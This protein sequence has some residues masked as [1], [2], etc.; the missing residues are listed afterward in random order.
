MLY[1][2]VYWK[3]LDVLDTSCIE[4]VR[5]VYENLKL[6]DLYCQYEEETYKKICDQI[7]AIPLKVQ[8]T[9]L[10]ETLNRTFN[11]SLA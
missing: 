11:R 9:I 10:R 1:I 2:C 8:R 7:Q 4:R 3:F 5:Q 6:P